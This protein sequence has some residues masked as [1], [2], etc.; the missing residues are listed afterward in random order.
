M[1]RVLYEVKDNIAVVSLNRPNKA[2]A[3]DLALLYELNDAF[4][5]AARDPSVKVI[6]LRANGKHFSSGH[7]LAD[8]SGKLGEAWPIIGTWANFEPADAVVPEKRPKHAP[9]RNTMVEGF[10]NREKE[11][12]KDM[13]ERWRNIPKPTIVAVQGKCIAGGLMLVWPMDIVVAADNALFQD[14]TVGMGVCG[15]EYFAH[16]FEVG[17]RKAK[18]MLYTGDAFKAQEAKELGMVCA[19]PRFSEY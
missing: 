4:D 7:D 9:R 8:K 17:T 13:C 3:Q 2:N 5:S 16:P 11:I 18:E 12:F 6:V 15:V 10:F 14:L 1:A 19:V